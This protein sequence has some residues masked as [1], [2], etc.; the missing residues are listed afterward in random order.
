MRN[1]ERVVA[2]LVLGALALGTVVLAGCQGSR[3]AARAPVSSPQPPPPT[4]PGGKSAPILA[5]PGRPSGTK[6]V[7]GKALVTA[8]YDKWSLK[9]NPKA[10][11]GKALEV[12][13]GSNE[14]KP[15]PAGTYALGQATVERKAQDATRW[16]MTISGFRQPAEEGKP[17]E[18]T[19]M[20]LPPGQTVEPLARVE[21]I[22]LLVRA[23]PQGN[24]A[25]ALDMVFLTAD[26]H[27]LTNVAH[28]G[29]D[30]AP[31]KWRVLSAKGEVVA[32]G[33]FEFG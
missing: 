8:S 31:P 2:G 13:G 12:G 9:L 7:A 3:Q 16:S 30:P 26:G 11:G 1:P 6:V 23:N 5:R 19:I 29:Q 10:A 20:E 27:R 18:D 28:N 33:S 15:V 22:T 4:G 21:P 25:V 32:S 17:P 24:A 14:Q